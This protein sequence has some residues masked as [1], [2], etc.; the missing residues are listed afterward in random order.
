MAQDNI[1]KHIIE[2]Q[3]TDAVITTNAL[4]NLLLAKG[5]LSE[6]EVQ[7]A[8]LVAAIE[9]QQALPAL[10][11]D[12]KAKQHRLKELDQQISKQKPRQMA[13]RPASEWRN[14]PKEPATRTRPY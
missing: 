12:F 3:H 11:N 13:L 4:M 7:A 1:E 5:I 2:S 6:K 9:F 10:I 8:K 14:K